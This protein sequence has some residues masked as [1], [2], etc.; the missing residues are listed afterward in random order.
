MS[1]PHLMK[2]PLILLGLLLLMTSGPVQLRARGGQTVASDEDTEKYRIAVAY[3]RSGDHRNAARI[4]QELHAS[5]PSSALY[6]EGVVRSLSALGQYSALLPLVE[7]QA[8][9]TDSPATAIVAGTLNARLNR[10]D[11]ARTWWEQARS[12]SGDDEATI[13]QIGRDQMDLLMNTDA[14]ESFV[15]ARAR[16]GSPTAYADEIFKLRSAAGDVSGAVADVLAAFRVDGDPI[17]AERRLSVLLSYEKGAEIIAENLEQLP[18]NDGK[19]LRLSAWFYRETKRWRESYDVIAKLDQLSSQ[20]GLELLVFAEGAKS[21]DQF[22]VA[23]QAYDEVVRRTKDGNI[24]MSAVFGA[25]RCLEL[26]MR[27]KSNPTVVEATDIIRR[28]DELITRFGTNPIVADALYFS[29]LLL[30]D[31]I[32]DM[33]ASRDRLLRLRSSWR[34]TSRAVDAGLRL[35]DIFIVMGDD[36]RA[37]SVLSEIVDGPKGQVGDRADVARLKLADMLLWNGQLDSAKILY[38]PLIE[39]TGSIASNDAID[40]MLLLNLALDDSAS[41]VAIARAEGLVARRRHSEAIPVVQSALARMR[42]A[43]MRDRSMLI[44]ARSYLALGDTVNALVMLRKIIDSST[45]SIYG[46]RAMWTYSDVVVAQR[47]P[48]QAIQV[49]EALLRIYPRSIIAPDARERIRRLRG[50]SR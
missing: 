33:D 13:V 31:V 37:R 29:A 1:L 46:D 21:S 28:Y 34:A 11:Q 25:V 40:R 49:L 44:C 9:K 7:K 22:D 23:L 20:P 26:Q 30:D 17:S 24:V 35:G 16:N 36:D 2:M 15:A 27:L 10:F 43:D 45:E 5:Q 48:Q 3:E 39:S 50:D 4:F 42:D 41:V 19:N 47:D 38:Q 6:F 14:L 8:K 18:Q 32:K 12:L